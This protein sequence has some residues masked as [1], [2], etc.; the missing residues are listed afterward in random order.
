MTSTD[1][2][3][4]CSYWQTQDCSGQEWPAFPA[5]FFSFD[6]LANRLLKPCSSPRV[7][8]FATW[9]CRTWG[10]RFVPQKKML[11]YHKDYLEL[12]NWKK[13]TMVIYSTSLRI[14]LLVHY[15]YF[16]ATIRLQLRAS[17]DRV[18]SIGLSRSIC[19]RK[20]CKIGCKL[21]TSAIVWKC[22][23]RGIFRQNITCTYPLC[24]VRLRETDINRAFPLSL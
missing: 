7:G 16:E 10:G 18:Y 19:R 11:L 6:L 12:G 5:S 22:V 9:A 13:A 20:L 3:Q 2:I 17:C 4:S 14:A 24:N 15:M 8:A 1:R 23:W 21:A